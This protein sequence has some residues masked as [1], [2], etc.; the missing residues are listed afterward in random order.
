MQKSPNK[1]ETTYYKVLG[2]VFFEIFS[3]MTKNALLA[4]FAG[5]YFD[6]IDPF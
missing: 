1:H 6:G 5:S 2:P 3:I 4:Q